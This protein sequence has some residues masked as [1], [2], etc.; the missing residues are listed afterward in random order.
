MSALA[1]ALYFSFASNIALGA[2]VGL[3]SV[4]KRGMSRDGLWLGALFTAACAAA[5]AAIASAAV[6]FMLAPLGIEAVSTFVLMAVAVGCHAGIGALFTL[7]GAK[8]AL[9]RLPAEK[10]S[11]A[12]SYAPLLVSFAA[13]LFSTASGLPPALAALAGLSCALGYALALLLMRAV[14]ARLL[15]SRVPERFRGEPILLV[16][17]G[18]VSLAFMA[19][20]GLA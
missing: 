7:A 20:Q 10:G 3:D 12:E 5:S 2:L 11:G 17:A 4:V 9:A 14:H 8:L 19:F 18:L 13:S 6:G 16:S 1:I 15:L